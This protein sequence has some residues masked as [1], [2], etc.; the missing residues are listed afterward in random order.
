VGLTN[1]EVM[2]RTLKN[3]MFQ[4]RGAMGYFPYKLATRTRI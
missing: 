3:I 1:N 2:H 4:T